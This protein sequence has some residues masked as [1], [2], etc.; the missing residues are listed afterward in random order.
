V[1]ENSLISLH[2]SK[3]VSGSEVSKYIE[4]GRSYGEIGEE[5]KQFTKEK[6]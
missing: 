5:N 3:S 4:L 2:N 1:F 6:I